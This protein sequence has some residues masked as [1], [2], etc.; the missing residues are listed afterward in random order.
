MEE[1]GTLSANATVP[2]VAG[3]GNSD[4]THNHYHVGDGQGG[5]KRGRSSDRHRLGTREYANVLRERERNDGV[6]GLVDRERDR[7]LDRN[8]VD[9]EMAKRRDDRLLSLLDRERKRD[10]G[11]TDVLNLLEREL[12]RRRDLKSSGD[13]MRISRAKEE[14]SNEAGLRAEIR[15]LQK[16]LKKLLKTP[17]ASRSCSE[18]KKGSRGRSG[19]TR[20]SCSSGR[21][22]PSTAVEVQFDSGGIGGGNHTNS[23]ESEEE[24]DGIGRASD[25]DDASSARPGVTGQD[26]RRRGQS[27]GIRFNGNGESG[28]DSA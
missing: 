11:G 20:T 15:A 9:R 8:M 25:N 12:D 22:R 21:R 2:A 18:A 27:L 16:D 10:R 17:I 13:T 4:V 7:E 19:G 5:K 6:L 23:D 26:I 28:S 3:L 1:G 24:D 14:K